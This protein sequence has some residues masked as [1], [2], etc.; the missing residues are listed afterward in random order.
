MTTY[1]IYKI[2]CSDD[3]ITDTYIGS[4]QNVTTRKYKHKYNCNNQNS[5][6]YNTKV[7][8]IIRQNGGWDN[9]NFVVIEEIKECSKIQAHIREEYH[10]QEIKANMNSVC[11][12]SGVTD[13]TTPEEYDKQY[14]E[15]N[16]QKIKER[17]QQYRQDNK[18]QI[19]KIKSKSYECECGSVF[20]S[21]DKLQHIKTNKHQNYLANLKDMLV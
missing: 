1:Y 19:S 14:R 9:W 11:C 7:Y 16:K 15:Y 8:Q 20:R 13:Y 21:C 18:E 3:N 2:Y 10:R 4:T 5:K 17:E 12:F 6:K